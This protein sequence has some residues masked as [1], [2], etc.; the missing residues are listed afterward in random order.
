M[1]GLVKDVYLEISLIVT[2]L[3]LI[4]SY[5]FSHALI[6]SSLRARVNS[7]DPFG[8]LTPFRQAAFIT[9]LSVFP[10]LDLNM[11]K[12]DFNISI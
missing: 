7:G 12:L 1:E 5:S 10:H 11:I 6:I 9:C 2:S 4:T 3:K 8:I